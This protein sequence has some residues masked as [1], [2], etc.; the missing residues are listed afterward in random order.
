[1]NTYLIPYYSDYDSKCDILTIHANSMEE[2]QDK[3]IEH[4]TNKFDDDELADCPDYEEFLV[5]LYDSHSVYL[6]EIHEI[7]EYES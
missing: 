3:L 4:Y 2:C 1:M 7:E 6:G 5:A